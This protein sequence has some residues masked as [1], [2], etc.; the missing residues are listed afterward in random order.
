MGAESVDAFFLDPQSYL[1]AFEPSERWNL[2][3][4]IC[5]I[6]KDR[7]EFLS[8][9]H[10]PIDID[11]IGISERPELEKLAQNVCDILDV[12]FGSVGILFSGNGLQLLIKVKPW[13]DKAYFDQARVHYKAVLDNLHLKLAQRGFRGAP[14][15][16]VW[17]TARLMRFPETENIKAG[18]TTRTGII[19]Q[20]HMEVLDWSLEKASGIPQLGL[21]DVVHK[22]VME[23]FPSADVKTILQECE[24][25]KFAQVFPEKITEPQWYASLSITSRFPDGRK[26]SHKMSEGHPKYN[27]SETDLKIT[28]AIESASPRTCKNIASLWDGCGT[29]K[30]FGTKTTSPITISGP[31]HLKTKETGFYTVYVDEEGNKKTKSPNYIDL[32]KFYDSLHPFKVIEKGEVLWRF[33]KGYYREVLRLGIKAFAQTHFNPKPNDRK[34]N[35]FLSTMLVHNLVDANWFTQSTTGKM[36]FTNGVYDVISGTLTPTSSEFGFRSQLPCAYDA[37][38]TAPRFEQFINEITMYRADLIAVL[39]E[40]LGYIFANGDCKR[41]KMLILLGEGEN[42][43]STFVDLIRS[44][45]GKYGHSNLSIKTMQDAQARAI[46]E[47]KLVNIAEENSKDAFKDSE[48]V[49]NMVAGGFYQVKRLY[50]QPYDVENR[51]KLVMLCNEAPRGID[52]THGFFR[53]LMIVPFDQVFSHAK[54]NRDDDLK[55]KLQEELPGIFNWIM[56]GYRRLEKQGTFTVSDSSQAA[57]DSYRLEQDNVY[58][59]FLENC[60]IVEGTS[61]SKQELYDDFTNWCQ[62]NGE[63]YVHTSVAVFKFIKKQLEAKGLS[64]EQTRQKIEKNTEAKPTNA[65]ERRVAHI[66]LRMGAQF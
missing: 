23:G 43:K 66:S 54:G 2:Y 58:R 34:R 9:E 32:M 48:L 24:F 27:F 19:L 13:E 26:F 44:L 15:P 5:N 57:L 49:K 4:T 40:Y 64:Y 35:E 30:H 28:Q 36:N 60:E 25:L 18:K 39:Q 10:I 42:G 21:G 63:R 65:R 56:E 62:S 45:A 52:Y 6:G 16:S 41:Q 53:R 61:E 29:C 12:P 59:W 3:Y 33:E 50:A 51:S 38:A 20:A 7:K 55:Y 11:D 31:D 22:S 8:Q 14:D 1:K 37:L 46:M 47:G 17:S